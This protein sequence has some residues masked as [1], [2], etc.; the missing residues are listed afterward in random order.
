MSLNIK[1]ERVCRLAKEAARVS[2]LSQTSVLEKALEAF[3][4][5]HD[6]A[7]AARARRARVDRLLAEI[8][9]R[10]TDEHRAAIQRNLDELYDDHGLPA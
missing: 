3:L 10:M 8:D 4:A 6:A 2:G 9:A 1:N 5:D 7:G